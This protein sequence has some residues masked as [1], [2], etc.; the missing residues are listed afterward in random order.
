VFNTL[1]SSNLSFGF[2]SGYS[3]TIGDNNINIGNYSGYSNTT[4][5]G[6]VKIGYESGYYETVSNK[7]FVDNTKRANEA[8]ARISSLIYGEF[9][10]T[11]ANQLIRFNSTIQLYQDDLFIEFGAGADSGIKDTG[12]NMVFDAD[13][14]SVGSRKFIFEN[15]IALFNEPIQ[16]DENGRINWN[17]ITANSVTLTVGSTTDTVTDLQSQDSNSYDIQ[18]QTGAPGVDLIVDFVSVDAFNWV[19]IIAY[20]KG[21]TNHAVS[22]QLYNWTSTSWVQFNAMETSNVI[23]DKSFFVPDDSD[24]IGTGGDAG[25]VR[26]KF[27]H[28]MTGNNAHYTYINVVALYQ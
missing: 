12:T 8:N 10:T 28:T 23:G 9:N 7:L 11:V 21:A 14:N 22:I 27:I 13:L 18:E 20:Y 25:K 19:Q 17:K 16:F 6:C 24:Y 1:G 15:G 3:N 5:A 26:V 2:N 4:G